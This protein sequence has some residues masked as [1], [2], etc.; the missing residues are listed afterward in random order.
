MHLK[1]DNFNIQFPPNKSKLCFHPEYS[2][3]SGISLSLLIFKTEN[4][5][6]ICSSI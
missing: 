2:A 5:F 3:P 1:L 6:I 4:I